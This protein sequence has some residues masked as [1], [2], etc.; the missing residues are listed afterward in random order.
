MGLGWLARFIESKTLGDVGGWIDGGMDG[1]IDTYIL[2]TA[3]GR[4][5]HSL[6][7][8]LNAYGAVEGRRER[9][10]ERGRGSVYEAYEVKKKRQKMRCLL[11]RREK[12][13][14]I[15]LFMM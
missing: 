5:S 10:G 8:L 9:G 7:R 12:K 11:L 2:L 15:L 13:N 3:S 4:R 1:G 6:P 14:I